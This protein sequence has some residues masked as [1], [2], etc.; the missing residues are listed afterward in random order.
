MK[1]LYIFGFI[2]C[3]MSCSNNNLSFDDILSD[4]DESYKDHYNQFFDTLNRQYSISSECIDSK[5]VA[6]WLNLATQIKGNAEVSEYFSE[7]IEM[8]VI[9]K[10]KCFI[11]GFNKLSKENKI[12]V[13]ERLLKPLYTDVAILR[14]KLGADF[15]SEIA[16]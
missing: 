16:K 7:K 9:N 6:K 12:A 14:A 4:F 2:F 13:R 3:A 5:E 10:T 15:W 1:I 11:E 8:L